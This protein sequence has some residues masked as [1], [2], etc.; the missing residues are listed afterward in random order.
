MIVS[1]NSVCILNSVTL[2]TFIVEMGCEC[3]RA[4]AFFFFF[5][6]GTEFL[7]ITETIASII[8]SFA[9]FPNSFSR[10]FSAS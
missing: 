5:E 7:N 9:V 10:K 2:L 6:I 1:V 8:F 3:V 4:R